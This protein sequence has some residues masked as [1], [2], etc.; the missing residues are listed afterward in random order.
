MRLDRLERAGPRLVEG[1]LLLGG[2]RRVEAGPALAQRAHP[3]F[4]LRRPDRAREL[5]H[6]VERAR[7]R[8]QRLDARGLRPGLLVELVLQG[9]GD[10]LVARADRGQRLADAV[11]R[12]QPLRRAEAR[13]VEARALHHAHEPG[14][15]VDGV[16]RAGAQRGIVR[17]RGDERREARGVEPE[18][19][20]EA[21]SVEPGRAAVEQRRRAREHRVARGAG[22]GR[23]GRAGRLVQG[24]ERAAVDDA[25]D[26]GEAHARVLV[27]AGRLG[28]RGGALGVA[29]V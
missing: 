1:A 4:V 14:L 3:A 9:A 2:E 20:L 28:E 7:H 25:P 29:R 21:R 22:L 13:L 16:E 24:R 10:D 8:V 19:A 27:G 11:V 18:Q 23:V 12:V 17:A 15:V 26:R 6:R 5:A